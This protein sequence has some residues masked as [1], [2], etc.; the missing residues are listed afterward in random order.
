MPLYVVVAALAVI[1][2]VPTLLYSLL[3]DRATERRV[4]RNLRAGPV[5]AEDVRGLVLARSP[6]ERILHPLLRRLGGPIRR[7]SPA[8]TVTAV[9]RRIELSGLPWSLESMMATKFGLGG[10]LLTGGLLWAARSGSR[11]SVLVALCAGAVGYVG[12]DAILARMARARQLVIGNQLPDTLDQLTIC[13]EAGLGF[14]AALARIARSGHGPLAEEIT[15]LLQELR[16][17][18]P[19]R[20]ALDNLLIRTD[21]PELRQFVHAVIQ[22]DSYGVPI[23]RV[24]RAQAGEQREKRRFRAEERAMK[25]P[26]KVIFPLVFCILPTVFIVV[27]GPAYVHLTHGL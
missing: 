9:E 22:A 3:S 24:L 10:G 1:L 8:G 13:V 14:D 19:R 26:V 20:E 21:V 18:V 23:S 11:S 4:V 5:R 27:L 6:V 12:P 17:G 25:L 16:V 15:L 2:S 7:L